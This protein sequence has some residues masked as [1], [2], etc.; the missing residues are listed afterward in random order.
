A[1]LQKRASAV[2][3]SDAALRLGHAFKR[4]EE[5]GLAH[6]VAARALWGPAYFAHQPEALALLYPK[7]FEPFVRSAAT[8]QG[9]DPFW[10]WSLMRRESAF[11]PN[12]TSGAD[13]RGLM[14]FIPKT[15]KAVAAALSLPPP[16]PSDL[17]RP[18]LNVKLA[19][20][21]LAAL[22][23]RFG[24]P[25]LVAAAYNAGPPAVLRWLGERGDVPLDAFVEEIPYKETRAYV[26][27]VLADYHLYHA[28]YGDLKARP[29]LDFVLPKPT[30]DGVSF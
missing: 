11:R 6:A 4:M 23:R 22:H 10:M 29:R 24:H 25:A 9:V 16:E 30:L 14:Q 2:R 3:G 15:A 5:F 19:A 18:E 17:Y 26:K 21:Y 1:E 8:S 27:Q 28:L 12:V 13:A 7:A 20:W